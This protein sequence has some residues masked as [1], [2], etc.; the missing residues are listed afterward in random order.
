M[1]VAIIAV[2]LEVLAISGFI[3]YKVESRNKTEN[4]CWTLLQEDYER[5]SPDFKLGLSKL[6]FEVLY[7]YNHGR[8]QY[9]L[10]HGDLNE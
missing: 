7:Y 6:P 8:L 3:Y 9:C 1:K 2:F 4:E 10:D 5:K